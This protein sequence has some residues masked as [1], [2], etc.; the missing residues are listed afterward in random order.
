MTIQKT[1]TNEETVLALSGWLDTQAAAELKEA[2]GALEDN[3]PRL[4]FDLD[5]L[6]YISS[7]GLRQIVD[8]HRKKGNLVLRHVGPEV[9]DILHMAGLDSR[10][11]IEA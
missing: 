10:L 8:A 2:V 6:E 3:I 7:A 5:K 9:K 1:S 11:N 4:V